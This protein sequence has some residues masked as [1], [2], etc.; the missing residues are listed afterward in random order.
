MTRL[1]VFDLDGTLI[2]SRQDLADATDALVVESGGT[3]LGVDA[4]TAMIGEGAAVLVRR[5]LVAAGLNPDAPGALER[6]LV[7]YEQ[8]LT[9]HTRPYVGIPDALSRLRAAGHTLAV[10]TNQ[11]QRPTAAILDTLGLAHHFAW[12]VGGDTPAGRKPDPGGLLG[13][14][15][16]ARTTPEE[17]VLVGDSPIDLET[18]RQAGVRA[19][20]VRY[21]FG[22]RF[23]SGAF[24][25]DELFADDPAEIPTRL[26]L[27]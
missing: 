9:T 26:A 3:P 5:A 17:T 13:L 6:F 8:R 16:L 25:G 15:A 21:G 22:F 24:R 2:D 1:V 23:E 19:C 12:T 27:C 14:V 7:H 10:L 18:A 4:V 20:L 11:P